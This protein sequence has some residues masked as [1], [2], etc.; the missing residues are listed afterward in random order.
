MNLPNNEPDDLRRAA[1]KRL[2]DNSTSGKLLSQA[3]LQRLQHEL[4]VYQ[5][6]LEIQ[7]EE[8]CAAKA[9]IDVSLKRYVDLFETAP[10]GYFN[11]NSE[12][13]ILD[14]NPAGI[15]LVGLDFHLLKGSKFGLLL[16][17][18]DRSLFTTILADVLATGAKHSG[19]LTIVREGG[20]KRFIRLEACGSSFSNICQ[21]VLIDL[22]VR[23]QVEDKLRLSDLA[24]KAISEGVVITTADKKIRWVNQEFESMT[25]FTWSEW[26]GKT[27]VQIQGVLTDP[28]TVAEIR[29][30]VRNG[31]EFHGE[32]LNYRKNRDAFWNEL[33]ISPIRDERGALTHFI[34][35]VRDITSRKQIEKEKQNSDE[36]LKF[37]LKA[38]NVGLW[39]WDIQTNTVYFSPEWKSQLGYAD[40]EISNRHDEWVSRVHPDE[41]SFVLEHR[42]KYLAGK[43]TAYDVEFRMRH[44]D[45]TWRWINARGDVRY[46]E[47][48]NQ[49]GM[50]GCHIDITEQKSAI[51]SLQLMKFCVDHTAD[52]VYW[53]SREGRIQYVNH[54]C[55]SQ[56]GY[57]RDELLSMSIWELDFVADYQP[58]LWEKHF[59]EI[60]R[61][62]NIILETRH[63]AKNG[64]EFP[65]EVNANYVKIGNRELNFAFAR[66]ISER[67]Q[68]EEERRK[69]HAQ[70]Q[71]AQKLEGLGV[72]A[73]GIAHDFN[74]LLTSMLGNASL[75]RMQ[76][77]QKS[78]IEGYL[79]EIESAAT[80]AAKLT[81]QMLAYSGKGRFVIQPL[82]LD[83]VVNQTMH[84]LNTIISKNVEIC[85][86]LEPASFEGDASQV[87]QI[88]MNL[89][90]NASD[91]F[92]GQP[93]QIRVRTGIRTLDASSL[94][95]PFVP[96]VLTAGEYAFV[97]VEDNGCG[98]SVETLAKIF[99][100]FFSTKMTGRGLGL[101]AVLGIIRSHHGTIKVAS[102][103][104]R[105]TCFEV[106]FP[107]I[108][109]TKLQSPNE[110]DEPVA[111]PKGTI[112]IVDDEEFVRRF[113]GKCVQSA[114]F[115]VLTASDGGEGLDVFRQHT[116]EISLVI[117]D[118]TMPRKNGL[119]VLKELRSQ[120]VDLPV[121]MMSGYSEQDVSLQ[122]SGV[123]ACAFIQKPF[124]PNEL[125]SRIG[126]LLSS[127]N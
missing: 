112:L 120:S 109:A 78:P 71:H 45:G 93:G 121:L 98:M 32:I 113:L 92:Q 108:K 96:D 90:T 20:E 83:V 55:C 30:A 4:Q 14:V 49:I 79:D 19:E 44:K 75:A 87:Q 43:I 100:P 115:S 57:S 82:Q 35:V 47:N 24:L 8:L 105:G 70:L 26:E 12:G 13:V 11:L 95:S 101:A 102:E 53:I 114:G 40:D 117:L 66:D 18:A 126:T 107:S 116:K 15:S 23:K 34:G 6:E 89:M 10:V 61:R 74:N 81:G 68:A 84:L 54:A 52:P 77:Q 103:L 28:K 39:H 17:E 64:R 119:E 106:L 110:P 48:G 41:R 22:T 38:S 80:N 2:K 36:R 7:N 51:E 37:A 104:G 62:G 127:R 50:L 118:L 97:E 33:S 88:I 111:S 65:V 5:V 16:A 69:L 59:E 25:G 63:R 86:N 85:L 42:E 60:K 58:G 125:I 9:E 1:E 73:S 29:H 67:K 123:G 76:L 122:T 99:D 31:R 94:Y 124:S 56:L 27:C 3:E 91:A 21:V 72:M 46:D